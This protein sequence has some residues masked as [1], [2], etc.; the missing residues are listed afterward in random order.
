MASFGSCVQV[1]HGATYR[2]AG[3]W[4]QIME[5]LAAGHDATVQMIDTSSTEPG[6]G[7]VARGPNEQDAV[8]DTNGC[9]PIV[10]TTRT[11]SESLSISKE[12]GRTFHRNEIAKL[13]SASVRICIA[14]GT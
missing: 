2:Q 1:R 3:I 14:R 4:D 13:L 9:S 5:A 7:T 10:D 12:H 6:Y 11:G 8:V